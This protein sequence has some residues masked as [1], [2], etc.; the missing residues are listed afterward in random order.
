LPLVALC[1]A[2]ILF[3]TFV[4]SLGPFLCRTA[5][6][7]PALYRLAKVEEDIARCEMRRVRLKMQGGSVSPQ[8]NTID[9]APLL[10]TFIISKMKR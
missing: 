5:R 6:E 3:I 10:N 8:L 1:F 4:T 7:E 9:L 2:G